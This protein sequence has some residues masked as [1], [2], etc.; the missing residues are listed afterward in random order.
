MITTFFSC[1]QQRFDGKKKEISDPANIMFTIR[2][3]EQEANVPIPNPSEH[4][5]DTNSSPDDEVNIGIE[6]IVR[7]SHKH[8]IIYTK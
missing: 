4:A 6:E 2:P 7:L 8:Q 5:D 1:N 3:I